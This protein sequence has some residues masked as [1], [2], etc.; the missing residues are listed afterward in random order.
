[1]RGRAYIIL[2]VMVIFVKDEKKCTREENMAACT[3]TYDCSRKGLC[4]E[5]VAHHRRAGEIP[6]CFFP[7]EVEKTYDRS[8]S[9]LVRC[10]Q[11]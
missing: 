11:K 7:P 8:L 1:M 3:C 2:K 6:G 5:C 9:R 10:F 4:C